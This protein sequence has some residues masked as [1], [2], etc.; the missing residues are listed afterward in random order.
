MK[1]SRK[2]IAETD[3]MPSGTYPA[4][5]SAYKLEIEDEGRAVWL[6]TNI[7]VRGLNCRVTVDIIDGKV[8]LNNSKK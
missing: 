1:E 6:S 3:F 7:G 5:W 4:R 8:Y 2:P